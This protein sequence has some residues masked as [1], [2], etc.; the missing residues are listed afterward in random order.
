[1]K[2]LF[3]RAGLATGTLGLI[4]AGAAAFSAFEAHVVNVTATISNATDITTSAITFGNV[5]PQEILHNPVTLALSSSFLSQSNTRA[6]SVD[7]VIKQKPK[8]ALIPGITGD[9]PPYAE[10][11][12]NS[13]GTFVCPTGYQAMPLLC[14]Y[15]SKTSPTEGDTSVPSFHGPTD[16]ASWT[17]AVSVATE[18]TGHLTAA[19]PSTT[20]DIDLHT[21]CFSGECA[22][23]W[24]SFVT[25]ANPAV[26]TTSQPYNTA[27]YQASSTYQG[28]PMGCDLWYE[29]SGIGTSTAPSQNIVMV[30]A[31][32]LATS[33]VDAIAN[34]T[35][36]FMYNDDNNTIDNTIGSFVSGPATPPYGTGSVEFT[37]GA[38]P[39]SRKN[40]ATYQFSGTSLSAITQMSFG[41]YSH[42]GV[43]SSTESPFFNFNVDLVNSNTFQGRLVYVPSTNSVTVP[44]DAWN[45][46]D[47]IN[48]GNALWT[49]SHFASNGNKW[50]D[51]NTNQYRTWNDIKTA[52]PTA[53]VLVSDPWL[54]VRVGEPGPTN[55]T[56]DVNFFSI[57]TGGTP[58]VYEFH[59]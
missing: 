46:F 17:D 44:Q 9:L 12:D 35:K 5:F 30:G 59:N 42:S 32:D 22:Q 16:L 48:G 18:A 55:Y 57:A 19:N 21:P 27:Y 7:Y 37:L 31:G 11:A 56:G 58:T 47:T 29:V 14:P 52:F 4:I 8:C 49:W 15:L 50:P 25:G 41:A 53:K 24:N 43:A 51:N 23:D 20:W 6:T 39:L 34:P 33:T 36:W 45:S 40:I 38:N 13:D 54:G 2:K 28:L 26:T 3:M 1:M 10:V